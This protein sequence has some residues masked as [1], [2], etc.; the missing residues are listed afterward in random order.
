MTSNQHLQVAKVKG[1]AKQKKE[2]ASKV[3]THIKKVG[4]DGLQKSIQSAKTVLSKDQT[5]KH[6]LLLS[7]LTHFTQL[8]VFFGYKTLQ[9]VSADEVKLKIKRML[10]D[11]ETNAEAAAL[12]VPVAE[13]KGERKAEEIADL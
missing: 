5:D 2:Q 6:K 7:I 12:L 4:A 10:P 13:K 1:F 8:S 11:A 3:L 9:V